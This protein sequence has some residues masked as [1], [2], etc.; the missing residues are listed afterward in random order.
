ME[1]TEA[2]V[3]TPAEPE[4]AEALAEPV[5]P[6]AP[7]PEMQLTP[8]V[9]AADSDGFTT[10]GLAIG[11]CAL[12]LMSFSTS[13]GWVYVSSERRD[14]FI[15]ISHTEQFAALISLSVGSHLLLYSAATAILALLALILAPVLDREASD[16]VVAGVASFGVAWGVT[17]GMW[18]M[19]FLWKVF[20]QWNNAPAGI[21]ILP[22]FGLLLGLFSALTVTILFSYL[23]VSRRKL[24]WLYTAAGMGFLLGSLL[25]IFNAKPWNPWNVMM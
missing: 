20:T 23:V 9:P 10:T 1:K 12:V 16:T 22:S 18:L 4:K 3:E 17:G 15:R 5:G 19:A 14:P 21:T 24:P 2:A 25:L 6:P 7:S 11:I 13:L 8:M